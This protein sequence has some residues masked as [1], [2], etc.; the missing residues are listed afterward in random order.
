MS[1]KTSYKSIK[2]YED[3]TY[4]KILLRMPKGQKDIIK[5]HAENNGE[6]VNGFI[7][8]AIDNQMEQDSVSSV[9]AAESRHFSTSGISLPS[10]TLEAVKTAAEATGEEVPEYVARAVKIQLKRD[11]LSLQAGINP[12]TGEKLETEDK[13]KGDT[14]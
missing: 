6:S 7:N 10:E 4:D 9:S 13:E 3:K 11:K 1:G 2:K 14:E 12:L 5:A 8:R